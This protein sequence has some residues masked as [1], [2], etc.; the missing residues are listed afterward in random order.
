M[1]RMSPIR[2]VLCDRASADRQCVTARMAGRAFANGTHFDIAEVEPSTR[3]T[4]LCATSLPVLRGTE[5]FE[6]SRIRS[7][8]TSPKS[9]EPA[10]FVE[11]SW[12][13]CTLHLAKML[14]NGRQMNT[15]RLSIMRGVRHTLA[16]TRSSGPVYS[17]AH[18]KRPMRCVS[19]VL[20]SGAR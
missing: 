9:D 3:M 14:Y 7:C 2:D 5:V 11:Q 1:S 18:W 13:C 10:A 19:T 12:T 8:T 15:I 16:S 20:H 6:P 4:C 17:F